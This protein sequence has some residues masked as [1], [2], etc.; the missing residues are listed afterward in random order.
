MNTFVHTPPQTKL[1][2]M[3]GFTNCFNTTPSATHEYFPYELVF[4]RLPKQFIDLNKTNYIDP[5]YNLDDYSKEIKF[6]LELVYKRA[7][8]MLEKDKAY[9][10]L[11]YDEKTKN[12]ELKIGDKVLTRNEMAQIRPSI[13]RSIYSRENRR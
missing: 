5:I 8:I 7:R 1:I 10:K 6:R 2:G 11:P 3:S 9:R 13:F 4:G 12:F